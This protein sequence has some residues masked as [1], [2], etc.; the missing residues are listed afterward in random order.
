MDQDRPKTG[1]GIMVF[2]D[3]KI[4]LAKRKNAHGAGE[5]AFPGGHLE[6]MESFADCASREIAEECGIKVK[7]IRFQLAANVTKYAPKHYVHIGLAAD[8]ESGEPQV[9]EPEKQEAW[10]WYDLDDLPKPIFEMARLQIEGHKTGK[11]Y[12]D[13]GD[14]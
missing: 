10:G 14:I 9:L 6:Y 7:N 13:V 4:L 3:G 5:Y 8:W 12:Y 11:N 2:K 1:V